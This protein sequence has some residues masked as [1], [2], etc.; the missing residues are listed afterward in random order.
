MNA[1]LELLPHALESAFELLAP[2]GVLAV[3]SFHSLEDRIVKRFVARAG[4]GLHLPA[5]HAGVRVRANPRRRTAQYSRDH[6][7][8]RRGPPKSRDRVRHGCV[9]CASWRRHERPG[10][11]GRSGPRA[12]RAGP[13]PAGS[14]PRPRAGRPAPRTAA[15]PRARLLVRWLWVPAL[16]VML[17]GI[18]FINAATLR[19]STRSSLTL[20]RTSEAQS[21]IVNLNQA[22]QQTDAQVRNAADAAAWDEA[23]GG[24]PGDVPERA[25]PDAVGRWTD[26]RVRDRVV[27]GRVP[28][29]GSGSARRRAGAAPPSRLR[30]R[31]ATGPGESGCSV[32]LAVV[33]IAAMI[34]RAGWLGTVDSSWLSAVAAGQQ[35][36]T[37]HQCRA[38]GGDRRPQRI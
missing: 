7:Q 16:A 20:Q 38:A 36:K 33:G 8:R 23:G 34:L 26:A 18:V 22:L 9:R 32:R 17:G 11:R 28:P 19:L 31:G 29:R 27:R 1:E 24:V 37:D 13:D 30:C 15:H 4:P 2:N 25:E 14:A 21:E 3:I 12:A 5:G 6:A 10:T 35:Q